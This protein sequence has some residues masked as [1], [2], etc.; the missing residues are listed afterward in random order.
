MADIATPEAN[1]SA[2][3][4]LRKLVEAALDQW[5]RSKRGQNVVDL[6]YPHQTLCARLT[7]EGGVLIA[8]K[9][10]RLDQ[11]DDVAETVQRAMDD[12]DPL[13][14]RAIEL[15]WLRGKAQEVAADIMG[16]SRITYRSLMDRGYQFL[17]G[18]LTA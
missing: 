10:L 2:R 12:M 1:Q 8:G 17:A 16:C 13:S 4:Q 14:C 9:G 3:D 18:R 11:T 5:R 6:G 15:L 7:G